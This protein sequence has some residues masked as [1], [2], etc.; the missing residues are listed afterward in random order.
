MAK[1]LAAIVLLA[2]APQSS[3]LDWL[4]GSWNGT[5]TVHGAPSTATLEVAP[6][7]GSKFVELRYRF[8]TTGARP[9]T[10]E[11]RGFYRPDAAGWHGQWFD[12][13]GATRPISGT[14]AGYTLTSE[15]GDAASERG[16]STYRRESMDRLDVTDEVLRKDG[17]WR[18]FAHHRLTRS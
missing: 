1:A 18:V 11:G 6:A 8:T 13:T 10:F 12:S 2:A 17:K 3:T 4:S 9:F 7:L 5:G 16:R 14:V 15:W